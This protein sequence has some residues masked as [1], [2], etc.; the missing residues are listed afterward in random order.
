MTCKPAAGE[1]I[2]TQLV[3]QEPFGATCEALKK[4]HLASEAVRS[5]SLPLQIAFNRTQAAF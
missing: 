5:V 2:T 1:H 4:P 3:T